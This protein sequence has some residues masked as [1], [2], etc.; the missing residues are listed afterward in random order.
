MK[1]LL[2]T[3]RP[4][5]EEKIMSQGL[6][7]ST[8]INPDGTKTEYW[9]ED[10]YYEFTLAEVEMLEGV[11][12]E[13]HTMCIEA[14]RY[15]AT[16]AMGDLGIG[17]EALAL[18]A[19]SLEN[20]D[21]YVYGRFDLAYDGINPP[22][23]LEYNADTP[24]GLIEASI[25][26][27]YWLQDVKPD[28]D[29]WN[30]IHEALIR[31][32]AKYKAG[33]G[34]TT[35]HVAHT[36]VEH[37]GEDWLT[38]AYIRDTADQAGWETVGINMSDIGWDKDRKRFVGLDD[39]PIEAMFKLY[40]WEMMMKEEFGKFVADYPEAIRWIEPAWKM[41]LS[42]KA[43]LAALW[44]LYPDHPNLLP[45]YIDGP[46]GMEEWVAK[47][48]HGREGDN[49]VIHAKGID[50]VQPGDYG[51]EGW[52]YQAW[53]PLP[54]FDGNRPVLGTWVVDGESVGVGIRESDGPITDYYCRFVPNTIDAPAPET[55]SL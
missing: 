15:M 9:H 37:S 41:F 5:W 53:C 7:F 13:L 14:A 35:L 8:T 2:S 1:R 38:A 16:G 3:P 31:S 27:W 52:C 39:E 47:P 25:A 43:L 19:K 49:I 11:T 23:M 24:T 44:H 26:Q 40:P 36:E 42:N 32:W 55:S 54:D 21:P 17:T 51:S 46:H 6:M 48:L 29:Q 45:S 4:D 34:L 12:E 33:T 18:A 50:I 30:G 22:K 20:G 28:H 10:A